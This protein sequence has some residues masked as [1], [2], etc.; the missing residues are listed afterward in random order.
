MKDS[1][2]TPINPNTRS[3]TL[4]ISEVHI[5]I[6]SFRKYLLNINSIPNSVTSTG[7]AVVNETVKF[8]YISYI[9]I[10]SSVKKKQTIIIKYD[11]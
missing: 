11:M 9:I 2:L 5:E 8:V 10:L 4:L 7:D 6:Y 1:E 3:I